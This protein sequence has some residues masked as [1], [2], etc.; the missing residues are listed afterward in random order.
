[1]AR[2]HGLALLDGDTVGDLQARTQHAESIQGNCRADSGKAAS[3]VR[4]AAR[5][6]SSTGSELVS[7][8]RAADPNDLRTHPRSVP[9]LVRLRQYSAKT[10][11]QF[12]Q[13]YMPP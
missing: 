5:T 4:S 2:C 7:D 12:V 3:P 13:D 10:T 9:R 6:G 8:G 1:M 11:T